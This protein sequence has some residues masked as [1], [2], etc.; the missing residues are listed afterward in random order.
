MAFQV[1]KPL[2]PAVTDVLQYFTYEHLPVHLQA[3]SRPIAEL[4]HEMAG[5]LEGPQLTNGLTKLLEAK[6]AFVR[7]ALK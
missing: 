7:A 6:D 1:P 2:H 3:I 4:A 5:K